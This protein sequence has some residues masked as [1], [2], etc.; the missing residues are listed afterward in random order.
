[1]ENISTAITNVGTIITA[2]MDVITG[3]PL[4]MVGLGGTFLLMGVRLFKKFVHFR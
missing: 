4:F 3:N 2:G 1:M